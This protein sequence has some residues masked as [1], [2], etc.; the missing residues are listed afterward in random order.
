M[1]AILQNHRYTGYGSKREELIGLDDV[2]V[3]HA[4]RFRR[5]GADRVLRSRRPAHP[6]I[7]SVEV[8]AEAHLI[9]RAKAGISNRP[10]GKSDDD[11]P[12]ALSIALN[13]L[14]PAKNPNLD[15]VPHGRMYTDSEQKGPPP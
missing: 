3:G 10:R 1:S 9:H 4:I 15:G 12:R 6:K 2:A 8:F 14:E 7:V 13:A 5:S 11:A